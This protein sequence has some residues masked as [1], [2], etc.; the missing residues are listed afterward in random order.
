MALGDLERVQLSKSE[1][2]SQG[3][4]DADSDPF[5]SGPLDSTEDAPDVRGIFFQPASPA[6]RDKLV[7]IYRDGDFLKFKD[8][9]TGVESTLGQ[10]TGAASLNVG[11]DLDFLLE[12]D[13]PEPDCNYAVTR[14]SGLVS[15]ETWT[16]DGGNL[17]KSTDYTRTAGLVSTIVVKI[18]DTDGTTVL[19][20]TTETLTRTG[21]LVTSSAKTRDT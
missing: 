16:R 20:Q 3:G 8:V 2:S 12:N 17:L 10:L 14:V 6:A 7:G 18:Y 15:Q 4:D 13:P 21:G 19:A 1:R 5:G 11:A 9:D